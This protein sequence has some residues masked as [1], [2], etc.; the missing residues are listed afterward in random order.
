MFHSISDLAALTT[1][2]RTPFF[3]FVFGND[4]MAGDLIAY[5]DRWRRD[6]LGQSTLQ[7][8]LT[9]PVLSALAHFNYDC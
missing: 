3:I 9:N 7:A 8:V 5:R 2:K 4:L 1:W 6:T